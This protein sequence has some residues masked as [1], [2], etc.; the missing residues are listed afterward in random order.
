MISTNIILILAFNIWRPTRGLKK[1]YK[2]IVWKKRQHQ[3][4]TY[5]SASV[6]ISTVQVNVKGSDGRQYAARAV[7]D[8]AAQMSYILNT[9]AGTADCKVLGQETPYHSLFGGNRLKSSTHKNYDLQL[10]SLNRMFVFD[11]QALGQ[12]VICGDLSTLCLWALDK[13]DDR[14]RYS[15]D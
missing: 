3:S 9:T 11:I 10:S 8:T 15:C 12:E 13:E 4:V 5:D 2:L 14:G 7:F 1:L 6:I